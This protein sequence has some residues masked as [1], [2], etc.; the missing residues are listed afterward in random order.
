MIRKIFN[1][2]FSIFNS[3]RGFTIL[4][5]LFAIFVLSLTIAGVFS[6][7]QQSLSQSVIAKDEV[8]A[9]YLTQEVFEYIRNKRDENQ[10]IKYNSGSGY[11]LAGISQF[12]TDPCY[13]G[14]VCRLDA[15]VSSSNFVYCNS[16]NWGSCPLLNQNQSTFLY[17]HTTGSGWTATNFRREIM[18]EEVNWEIDPNTGNPVLS[19]VLVTVRITWSKGLTNRVFTAKAILFN[20]I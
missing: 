15:T 2:Q 13:F 12:S 11:W 4:E 6:A 19:E 7:V 5:S 16:S 10:L 18:L 14:R 20:R 17:G 9:F 8:R 3:T 1:F